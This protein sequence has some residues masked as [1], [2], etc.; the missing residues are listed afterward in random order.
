[1]VREPQRPGRRAFKLNDK[2]YP[3]V[4]EARVQGAVRAWAIE[5]VSDQPAPSE[6]FEFELGNQMLGAGITFADAPG[7]YETATGFDFAPTGMVTWPPQAQL[8]PF[9]GIAGTFPLRV[10]VT[11]GYAYVFRD[12]H[13][14]KYALSSGTST[15]PIVEIHWLGDGYQYT[16]GSIAVYDGAMYV[17]VRSYVGGGHQVFQ[18]RTT[19]SVTTAEV[20]TIA[21]SGTPTGGTYTI[22]FNDGFGA[23]R[24]TAAIAF[25]ATSAA[26]Q[27]ALRLLGGLELVTVAQSGSSPNFT[28]TVTMTGA[29][30]AAGTTSPP[31]FTSASSL[32]GGAPVITHATT[33]PGVGDRW[34]LGPAARTAQAFAVQGAALVRGVD[35]VVSLAL[36]DPMTAGN[37]GAEYEVGDFD[38]NERYITDLAVYPGG[39][40]VVGRT[41]GP[42]VINASFVGEIAIPELAAAVHPDNC[43]GM[44][45]SQGYILIPHY[46]GLIRWRPGAWSLVGIDQDD[47]FE[48]SGTLGGYG[49]VK[50]ILGWGRRTY[51]SLD[52]V[53]DTGAFK[54]PVL[55]SLT[56]GGQRSGGYVLHMHQ[57]GLFTGHAGG[58]G[59]GIVTSDGTAVLI[60]PVWDTNASQV[61]AQ[62]YNP[63][64]FGLSPALDPTVSKVGTGAR[65]FRSSRHFAPSRR[66]QKTYLELEGYAEIT[67]DGLTSYQLQARVDGGAAF[68]LLQTPGGVASNLTTTGRFRRYFPIG[69]G[70]VGK[71]VLIEVH[72]QSSGGTGGSLRLRDLAIRGAFDPRA[73][74]VF[75]AFIV[76]E[77]GSLDEAGVYDGRT[78]EQILSDLRGLIG[79]DGQLP[80]QVQTITDPLGRTGW[81]KVLSVKEQEV[82]YKGEAKPLL[83][84]QVLFRKVFA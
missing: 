2:S 80:T 17:P 5:W 81:V 75:S 31:Q 40:L 27:A 22:T 69:A 65:D 55:L 76:V 32:T 77:P 64:N 51:L 18:R 24:T 63:G 71:D 7:A 62:V 67:T 1:M 25:N 4:D 68:D 3:L 28:H 82:L 79:G 26:V 44:S 8:T 38:V 60:V 20:Q 74:E 30:S 43:K 48:P 83:G 11:G 53:G 19:L 15:W 72:G 37:W 39:D 57:R 23:A 41:D 61:G 66:V 50:G 56:P 12:S 47:L 33:T 49:R 6:P 78:M 9:S 34:D 29:P 54:V 58:P 16:G 46:N 14:V 10:V 84:A 52:N 59:A 35:N 70:S 42:W 45:Y 21:I 13:V 73:A 36:T